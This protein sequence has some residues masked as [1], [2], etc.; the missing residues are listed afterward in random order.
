MELEF[1]CKPG[2][3]LEWFDYWRS[4]CHDWLL[5]PRHARMRTSACA[6]TS[7]RS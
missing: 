7:R 6:T 4:F 2:T 1:F 5:S 3:D